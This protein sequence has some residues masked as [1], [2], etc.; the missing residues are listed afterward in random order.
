[1][2]VLNEAETIAST[3]RET[4]H[5]CPGAE[6]IVVD[7]GSA[8]E[9][10]SLARCLADRVLSSGAGRARQMNAGAEDASGEVL[11]FLH[12]DTRVP[13]SAETEIFEALA[14]G[15]E[16]G[17][18]DVRIEGRPK[19]LALVGRLMN[20]RSRLT[21]V[22]TGD[23]AMFVK[24]TTFTRVGGFAEMPLMED[25][26]LSKRLRRISRPACLRSKVTTSG[27]R[28]EANGPM[29]TIL[30]MWLL[31]LAYVCG[32]PPKRLAEL[33]ARLKSR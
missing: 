17:R 22:A 28:W 4:R 26:A 19:I 31:R 12:A 14:H 13:A 21:G 15:P 10:L 6:I 33:Y 27:R 7:G 29:R 1:M 30:T 3:L 8:D 16:W 11:L 2:P 5:A 32:V 9:T 24:K 25:I 23:Q 18:F 20:L